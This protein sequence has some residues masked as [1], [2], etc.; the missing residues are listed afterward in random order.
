MQEFL[1]IP[2]DRVRTAIDQAPNSNIAKSVRRIYFTG[3]YEPA[4]ERGY[5]H[6]DIMA[7]MGSGILIKIGHDYFLLTARH[8]LKDLLDY[9]NEHGEFY[10]ESPFWV[11]VKHRPRWESLHDFL[12]PKRIW[13]IGELITEEGLAS[14]SDVVLVELFPPAP[15]H[16]PDHFID[17][18]NSSFFLEKELFY[19]GQFLMMSGYPFRLN[20]YDWTVEV[21]GY[22]HST[23]VQ[24]HSVIGT[25]EESS[26]LGYISFD[27]MD[28]DLTHENANGMSGGVIYN[29][30]EELD[31]IKFCGMI[32]TAGNNKCH[33]LPSYLLYDAIVNYAEATSLTVDPAADQVLSQD[34]M[35]QFMEDYIKHFLPDIS[36]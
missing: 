31:D 23:K 33:F 20:Q 18:A 25:F 7:G 2:E 17:I 5:W 15:A 21:P 12:M 14:T 26:H 1:P 6:T 32:L 10:N 13:E 29:V 16:M 22:T 35:V 34:K 19:C 11:D 30:E 9:K 4:K 27:I 28:G 3:L 36:I 24:R 8:V